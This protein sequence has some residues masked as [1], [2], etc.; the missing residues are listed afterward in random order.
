MSKS[1][2]GSVG[3]PGSVGSGVWPSSVLSVASLADVASEEGV[4]GDVPEMI[5]VTGN[6]DRC[7]NLNINK[8][9]FFIPKA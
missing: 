2:N 4:V 6:F 7:F 8:P 3:F 9:K 5:M 1:S